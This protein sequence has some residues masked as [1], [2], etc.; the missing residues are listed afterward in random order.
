MHHSCF[1]YTSKKKFLCCVVCPTHTSIHMHTHKIKNWKRIKHKHLQSISRGVKITSC[2][3]VRYIGPLKINMADI[4]QYHI[5]MSGYFWLTSL[6]SY[7]NII[8]EIVSNH[9]TR[10]KTWCNDKWMEK[11]T[12]IVF[13]YY[14]EETTKMTFILL[15]CQ[16]CTQTDLLQVL[17]WHM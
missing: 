10:A 8:S 5:C 11:T 7:P 13:M 17:P 1:I 14:R 6:P 3:N 15:S 12:F 9:K 4:W 2:H 16:F